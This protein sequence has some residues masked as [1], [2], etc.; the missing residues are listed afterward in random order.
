MENNKNV[1]DVKTN[2]GGGEASPTAVGVKGSP[3]VWASSA[4]VP[5]PSPPLCEAWPTGVGLVRP[6]I[7]ETDH[8]HGLFFPNPPPTTQAF[9]VV[10]AHC[11]NFPAQN[12][13][14]GFCWCVCVSLKRVPNQVSREIV[15]RRMDTITPLVGSTLFGR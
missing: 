12:A 8:R 15:S 11:Q 14:E 6:G 13:A 1:N 2:L 9:K 10:C 7:C 3:W 5:P 4:W